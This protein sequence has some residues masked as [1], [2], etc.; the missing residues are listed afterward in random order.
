MKALQ[1]KIVAFTVIFLLGITAVSA[2]APNPEQIQDSPNIEQGELEKR[3]FLSVFDQFLSLTAGQETVEPGDDLEF[4]ASATLTEDVDNVNNLIKIIEIYRCDDSNCDDP[5]PFV[6]ADRT[7]VDILGGGGAISGGTWDWTVT[8]TVP[9]QESEYEAV[10]YI[11]NQETQERISDDSETRFTV[12]ESEPEPEPEPEPEADISMY[13]TP[14]FSKNDESN[15]VT[16]TIGLQNTG[17]ADMSDSNIVEMQVRPKGSRPL[18]FV[19]SQRVCDD[20]YPENVHK[21][22]SLDAGDSREISLESSTGLEDGKSY[23][24]YFLTRKACYPDNEKVQPIENS[25]NAG[26]F[27]F[28]DSQQ[29]DG[30]D[31]EERSE[32]ADINQVGKP[33]LSFDNGTVTATITFENTGGDMT[34]EDIVEMQVRPQGMNPLS[35][36]FGDTVEVCD[37]NYPGNVHRTFQLDKGE[38]ATTTLSTDAVEKGEKYTVY[39]LTRDG[40]YPDN[41]RV[42]PIPNSIQAGTV[43]YTKGGGVGLPS[44]ESLLLVILGLIGFIVLGGVV[45]WLR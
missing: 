11:Y 35:T 42:E 40:C 43:D 2:Q 31:E 1:N 45:L 6:E 37:E 25:Y 27:T 13:Q 26:S 14:S 34:Q 36:A 20:Q 21:E 38:Q 41:E 16:G 32:T 15:T 7:F 24:V 28:K 17:G 5:N 10:S 30:S 4:E 23:T 8:Y 3:G 29:D 19:S 12:S 22:Y 9:N 33:S 44:S 18:S 39:M